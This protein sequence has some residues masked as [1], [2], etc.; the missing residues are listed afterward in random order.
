MIIGKDWKIESDPLNITLYRRMVAKKSGKEYW[1]AEG[2]Y[3]SVANAL[4]G[5][6]N[7]EV[8][9]TGMKEFREVAKKIDGLYAQI[10]TALTTIGKE[11]K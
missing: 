11:A 1:K 7:F 4:K 5:L 3:S 6:V 9:E 8:K 2:Y 10:D